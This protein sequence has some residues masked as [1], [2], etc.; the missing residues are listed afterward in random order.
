MLIFKHKG[1]NVAGS[2]K[3]F[4]APKK[5][6]RRGSREAPNAAFVFFFFL[7]S[8]LSMQRVPFLERFEGVEVRHS[9]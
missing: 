9:C 1:S 5:F 3:V 8:A 2:K 7:N 4:E 6:A